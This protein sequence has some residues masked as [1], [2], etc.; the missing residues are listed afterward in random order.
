MSS[1]SDFA[2]SVRATRYPVGFSE[3]FFKSFQ[4]GC[5]S[6][7]HIGQAA[8]DSSQRLQFVELVEELLVGGGVLGHKLGLSVNGQH[9]RTAAPAH[10]LEEVGGVALEVA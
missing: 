7:F 2:E 6:G 3:L 8:F 10:P 1:A 4:G 9:N 5:A